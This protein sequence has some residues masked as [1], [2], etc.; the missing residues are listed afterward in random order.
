VTHFYGR[1]KIGERVVTN[2]PRNRGRNISILGRLSLDGL[3]VSMTVI[4]STNKK[5]FEIYSYFNLD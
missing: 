3:V 1:G 2:A 4:G 5:I